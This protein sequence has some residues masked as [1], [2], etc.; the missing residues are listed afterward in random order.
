MLVVVNGPIAAGKST[1]SSALAHRLRAEGRSVAV[2]GLDEVFFMIRSLPDATL[3][4]TW[5]L[6]LSVSYD[7]ALRRVAADETRGLSKHPHFLR[8]THEDFWSAHRSSDR[9]DLLLD[10][11]GPTAAE[12]ADLVAPGLGR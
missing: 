3:D 6:A 4:E 10:T 2:V 9:P 11:H 5:D 7:E 12:L 8:R 1:F